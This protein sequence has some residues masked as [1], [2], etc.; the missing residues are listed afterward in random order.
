MTGPLFNFSTWEL[1]TWDYGLLLLVNRASTLSCSVLR[2]WKITLS[3]ELKLLALFAFKFTIL[4]GF[5]G[6][7]FSLLPICS[8]SPDI[9][10][11][12]LILK[13]CSIWT[14][15]SSWWFFSS[16][17]IFAWFRTELFKVKPPTSSKSL[18]SSLKNLHVHESF[19]WEWF[20]VPR[21]QTIHECVIFWDYLICKHNLSSIRKWV[22]DEF[23]KIGKSIHFVEHTIDWFRRNLVF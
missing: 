17:R 21:L 11:I 13:F 16:W 22:L 1:S 3:L 14:A 5:Y 7:W 8:Q 19:I 2:S 12:M 18:Y 15:I 10:S 23:T 6:R 20:S 9:V 4:D